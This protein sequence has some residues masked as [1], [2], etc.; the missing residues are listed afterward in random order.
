MSLAQ[1]L[2][3]TFLQNHMINQLNSLILYE[4]KKKKQTKNQSIR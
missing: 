3:P 2:L 1:N 4:S